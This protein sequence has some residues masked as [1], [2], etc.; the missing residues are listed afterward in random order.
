MTAAGV[1]RPEIQA[2]RAIAALAVVLF[3]LWP[4]TVTGGY[5]GVDVF[6]AISGYLITSLLLRELHDHGRV[7]LP[8]FWARRARRLLPAAMTVLVASALATVLVV[9]QPIWPVTMTQI[10]AAAVYALNWVLAASA[11]DYFAADRAATSVQHYW[12][13]SVEE[14]FYLVW[15]VALTL[16]WAAGRLSGHTGR[17]AH[18]AARRRLAVAITLVAVGSFG[19][20]VWYSYA[21][22][23]AAYFSTFTHAWE[24]AIGALLALVSGSGVATRARPGAGARVV[25]AWAGLAMIALA[26]GW[27]DGDTVFPGWKAA[28]PVV[29]ALAVIAAGDCSGCR[30]SPTPI[31]G[32]ALV[33]WLGDISYS[34]YLWHWPLIVITPFVIGHPNSDAT[35]V[36]LLAATLA[37]ATISKQLIE[38]P[39]RDSTV[40]RQRRRRTFV[41]AALAS[42]LVVSGCLG[43]SQTAQ[44][45]V[46][47]QTA[48]ADSTAGQALTTGDQCF[49][50][51]AVTSA[52]RCQN[53]HRVDPVYLPAAKQSAPSY[54]VNADLAGIAYTELGDPNGSVTVA[55][56]GDSHANHYSPALLELAQ[57]HGWRLMIIKYNDCTPSAPGWSSSFATDNSP[58]CQAHRQRLL[59]ALPEA[60]ID[61]IVTSSRAPRYAVEPAEVQQAAADAFT[62]MWQAWSAAGIQV[63]VIADVPEP[64]RE[65][66]DA[67]DCVLAHG[68]DLDPCTSPRTQVVET[69]AMLV[70][71]RAHPSEH[72][73]VLDLTSVYCDAQLCHAVI[74]GLPV[75]ADNEHLTQVWAQSLTP[76]IDEALTPA[77]AAG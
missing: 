56:V 21:V 77:L 11:V 48:Q 72:L 73:H 69:D 17:V 14:Q 25:A 16:L 4:A 54:P 42:A 12:S 31:L 23:A 22:P 68:A 60:G 34:L 65:V 75:Y 24:L 62:Q 49:G 35:K 26:C 10:A 45:A 74:G 8:E 13:L 61:V 55:L 57:R 70:A 38:D 2:L 44:R 32:S 58:P 29:G 67:G 7:D 30:F 19:Y 20:S 50:A 1:R 76:L 18:P 6:F 33:Q 28:L 64:G 52:A 5:V 3:H 63:L 41:V 39:I 51:L 36:L 53:L 46:A 9:P 43:A 15:P 27:F 47:D 66:G 37:L 40:L 71:A 59:Q